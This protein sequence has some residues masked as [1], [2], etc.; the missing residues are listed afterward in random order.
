VDK[1]RSALFVGS[2]VGCRVNLP[3]WP[4]WLEQLAR[5]CVEFKDLKAAELIRSRIESGDFLGAASVYKTCRTIPE[6]ERLARMAE[7]F[8][9][10]PEELPI[11]RLQ[12]LVSLPVS[13]MI[14]TNYDRSLHVG[15][16]RFKQCDVMP[17]ELR[18][19]TMKNGALISEFFIA[20]IHGRAEV[21]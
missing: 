20:R 1:A 10:K 5:I 2:G 15:C 6:A 21:P 19:Q 11:E 18:D 3:S 16:A 12:S 13:G 7:P 4:E 14:T 9:R 8:R 17:L